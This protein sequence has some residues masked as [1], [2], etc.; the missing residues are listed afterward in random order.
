MNKRVLVTCPPML[1]M[2][3]DFENEFQRRDL[4]FHG[5]K[6][7]QTLS[8]AELIEL[9]PQYDG[10]IMGDDPATRAVFEAGKAGK[11]KAA[12]K[13]GIGVDNV[14]F[15]AARDLK[16][17]ITNTP[18]MFGAEVADL[19]MH[20]LTALARETFGIDRSIRQ[21][22]WP[23]PIGISLAEKTVGVVGCGD[24]GRNVIKRSLA[25]EMQISVFDPG[26]TEVPIKFKDQSVVLKKWPEDVESL[27]FLVFTCALNPDNRHMFS[28]SLMAK[29]QPDL[30]V[31]NV[32][33]GPL[34]DEGA[35]ESALAEG[36]IHSVAL[37]V[38]ED[39]PLS[40]DSRLRDFPNC[41]FGSHNGS[42]TRD[43]VMRTS[44]KAISLIDEF[45]GTSA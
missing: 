17:P 40:K 27:D 44:L 20:Y 30:R 32:A 45:L 33:R 26:L 14:D 9:L 38:F 34:I 29:C 37:D 1:G 16:I 35:L 3:A 11:L 24:I 43:A 19:A 13:W 7:L 5:P 36:R 10:W 25:A 12:V 22:N 21:G 39:E 4:G 41:I 6:V 23:K 28:K 8:E 42:N 18:G 15:A 31:V 2:L